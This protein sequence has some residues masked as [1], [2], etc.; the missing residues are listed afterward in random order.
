MDLTTDSEAEEEQEQRKGLEADDEGDID[1]R[2]QGH[3]AAQRIGLI[4]QRIQVR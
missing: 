4:Q 2:S 3:E 1:T